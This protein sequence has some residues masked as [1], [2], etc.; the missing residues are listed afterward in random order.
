MKNNDKITLFN[1]YNFIKKL[2][3]NHNNLS[4]SRSSFIH[5]LKK[6]VITALNKSVISK[7]RLMSLIMAKGRGK[8]IE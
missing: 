8:L 2:N 1:K 3:K 7:L 4:L 5:P 6:S